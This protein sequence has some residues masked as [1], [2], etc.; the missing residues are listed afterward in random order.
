MNGMFDWFTGGDTSD[1]N[2]DPGLIE[3]FKIKAREWASK[4]VELSKIDVSHNPKLQG[5]KNSLLKW[6]KVIRKGVESIT[7]TIDE[8][9]NAGLGIAPLIPIAVIA[10]AV[11]G[12]TKWSLSYAEFL[13]KAKLERELVKGGTSPT[14]ASKVIE[15][16]K[17]DAKA[18]L[19][20][21]GTGKLAGILLILGGGY[22]LAKQ[23]GWIK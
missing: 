6:A 14:N 13:S 22:F 10:A 8:L 5:E 3:K 17:G 7:G 11:A 16:I 12:M 21:V 15:R 19:V 2:A 1:K 18:P 23:Q 4:V 9:D 20:S